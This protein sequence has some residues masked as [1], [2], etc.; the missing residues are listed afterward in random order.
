MP[1]DERATL[2]LLS[3]VFGYQPFTPVRDDG[4][5]LVLIGLAGG[6]GGA[7]QPRLKRAVDDDAHQV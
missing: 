5:E 4:A 1:R 7:E 3:V 6:F 2:P